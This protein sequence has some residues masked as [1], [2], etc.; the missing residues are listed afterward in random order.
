MVP[1][2]Q[3]GTLARTVGITSFTASGQRKREGGCHCLLNAK[4]FSKE[5]GQRK[6]VHPWCL[7]E[8]RIANPVAKSCN[9]LD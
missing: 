2:E 3:R 1:G 6:V 5:H 8:I 9:S 4:A 7:V